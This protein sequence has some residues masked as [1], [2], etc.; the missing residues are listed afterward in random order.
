MPHGLYIGW[1]GEGNLGDEVMYE[2]CLRL[3]PE[4]RWTPV[5]RIV[6][7]EAGGSPLLLRAAHAVDRALGREVGLLGGGTVINRNVGWLNAYRAI[8]ARTRRPVPVFAPGVANPEFWAREA[9]WT[10]TRSGWREALRELPVVGV[11]GPHSVRLLEE[12]GV[13]GVRMV[14]D[15]ALVLSGGSGPRDPSTVVL[16][17]GRSGGLFWGDEDAAVAAL[18]GLA[19]RLQRRGLRVLLLPVW[20]PDVAVCREVAAAGG[21]APGD[22]LPVPT[23]AAGFF[24]S[25]AGASVLVST[26]LHAAV[27][28]ACAHLPFV[29]LEYRPKVRDFAAGLG[30]EERV[31]RTDRVDEADLERRVLDLLGDAEHHGA[32]L[33]ARVESLRGSLTEYAAELRTILTA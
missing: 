14:G 25:V 20:G 21:V 11:R 28:A 13:S 18:G 32:D 2:A 9:G 27:L 15:P 4:V 17:A 16:N 8:R 24:R 23:D 12:A 30:L 1:L 10:D 31:V 33:A 19:G 22:V 26:K 6:G 3:L 5:Q 29:A 7:K